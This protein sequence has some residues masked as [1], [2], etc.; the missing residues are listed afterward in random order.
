ME[1]LNTVFALTY[2]QVSW[3][4]N[5]PETCFPRP[6]P[7]SERGPPTSCLVAPASTEEEGLEG[8]VCVWMGVCVWGCG[9]EPNC[10]RLLLQNKKG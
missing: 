4:L 10:M 5:R 6:L 2:R 7:A 9:C 3:K 8:K 1:S